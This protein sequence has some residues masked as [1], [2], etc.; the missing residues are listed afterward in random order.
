MP[1]VHSNDQPIENLLGFSYTGA[2]RSWFSAAK[3]KLVR[4]STTLH[5]ALRVQAWTLR[6]SLRSLDLR[7]CFVVQLEKRRQA[8]AII[9]VSTI[10]G[11][12]VCVELQLCRNLIPPQQPAICTAAHS[13]VLVVGCR[14]TILAMRFD[15]GMSD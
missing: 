15:C 3:M 11:C 6:S 1:K 13:N 14:M 7:T 12:D 9:Q 4:C 10:A 5:I 2:H 8:L